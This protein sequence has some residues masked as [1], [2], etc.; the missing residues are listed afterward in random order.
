MLNRAYFIGY[1]LVQIL[2]LRSISLFLTSF[3]SV[4]CIV[5]GA[6]AQN[7]AVVQAPPAPPSSDELPPLPQDSSTPSF[8]SGIFSDD[9]KEEQTEEAAAPVA[10]APPAAPVAE[11]PKAPEQ[12]KEDKPAAAVADVKPKTIP[13]PKRKPL[14]RYW[15]QNLPRTISKRHY[16]QEN[17]HLPPAAYIEE[18]VHLLF[19]SIAQGNVPVVRA[20]VEKYKGVD[21]RDREGNTPLLYAA[22]LGNIQI[23]TMLIGMYADPNVHNVYQTTPLHAVAAAGRADLTSLLLKAGA[24]VNEQDQSGMTPLMIAAE[25][26]FG[27]VVDLLLDANAKFDI[28][29]KDGNTALH[30]A[31]INPLPQTCYTLLKRG[32]NT[33]YRNFEGLTPL[34]LSAKLGNEQTTA[35]LIKA[36]ADI[37]AADANERNAA[38]LAASSGYSELSRM[39]ESEGVRRKKLADRMQE[40]RTYGRYQPHEIP[41]ETRMYETDQAAPMVAKRKNGIPLP[42]AKPDKAMLQANANASGESDYL[43]MY[44]APVPRYQQPYPVYNYQGEPLAAPPITSGTVPVYPPA[45]AAAPTYGAQTMPYGGV[46]PMNQPNQPPASAYGQPMPPRATMPPQQPPQNIPPSLVP[47]EPIPGGNDPMRMF[48]YF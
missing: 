11:A 20:L 41:P 12:K 36:G 3:I 16:S 34:M 23:V 4:V 28:R 43:P 33:E 18:H 27:G 25:R 10:P 31:C 7:A 38:H 8:F 46:A 29:R 21:V 35:L 24:P 5:N 9:E 14:D 17:S 19:N 45:G 37:Y 26:G 13:I 39:I 48:R 22:S 2:A 6:V 42:V 47:T 30:L 32:A 44:K 1:N 15:S 40:I